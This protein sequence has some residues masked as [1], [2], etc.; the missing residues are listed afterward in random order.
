VNTVQPTATF[1]VPELTER[2]A[3][4]AGK[5]PAKLT[6]PRLNKVFLRSRLFSLLDDTR[7]APVAWIEAPPGAGKTTLVASW[8]DE[9]KYRCLWYQIDAR[10][11]DIATFFHYLGISARHAAPRFKRALPHLTP[12]Y[13]KGIEAFTRRYFEEL[14]ARLAPGSVV[15][16][17]NVQ[18]AGS[19]GPLYSV[20]R[21]AFETVPGHVR[22]VC[23]SRGSPAIEL[24]RLRANGQ[25]GVIEAENLRLTLEETAGFVAL[26]CGTNLEAARIHE[27]TGGWAAGIVLTLEAGRPIEPI[28]R[29]APQALFDYFAAEIWLRID[30]A[31]RRSL[32]FCALLP[33]MPVD[34]IEAI[35]GSRHIAKTLSDFQRRNYFTFRLASTLPIYD[36]HPLFREFLLSRAA[37]E[38][39]PHVISRVRGHAA[40]V[41]EAGG[42]IEDA[43]RL[44]TEAG[45]WEEATRMLLAHAP[46]LA[47]QGRN[48]TLEAWLASLP[49]SLIEQ[50][51]W[52]I[53]WRGRCRMYIN[54][55]ECREFLVGAF[56]RFKAGKD[57]RGML[58]AW[59]SISET[60]LFGWGEPR[61]RWIGEFDEIMA[62]N[63]LFP[64]PEIEARAIVNMFAL[65]MLRDIARADVPLLERK[66]S[67]LFASTQS[68][69]LRYRTA[70]LL[71]VY[72]LWMGDFGKGVAIRQSLRPPVV[73]PH[74]D[75]VS[76]LL[77]FDI[78][79]QCAWMRGDFDAC[80]SAV[81]QGLELA[82]HTGV[83]IQGLF[84]Y[85]YGIA[86]AVSLGHIETASKLLQ[87]MSMLPL[88]SPMDK[89]F[90]H[91]L[92]ALV[93]WK[94]G[95]F[96]SAMEDG[97]MAAAIMDKLDYCIGPY[98]CHMTAA[99]ACYD[100]QQRERAFHHLARALRL[101]AG[102]NY[103]EYIA[104]LFSAR[105][106][107][108][109]G[110]DEDGLAMLRSALALGARNGYV[111]FPWWDAA[112]MARLCATALE[113]GIETGYVQMLIRTRSL[114]PPADSAAATVVWPWPVRIH[115]LGKFA[116]LRDGEPVHY[117]GKVQRRPLALL[118][119]LIAMGGTAVPEARLAEVMWPDA[120]GDVAH[121][122]LRPALHRLRKLIGAE[123]LHAQ[124]GRLSLD[125]RHC[126]VDVWAV[127]RLLDSFAGAA[128]TRLPDARAAYHAARPLFTLYAG[129][130]LDG[131]DFPEVIPLRERLRT[132][133][134]RQA[135]D[136]G[137]SL[138]TQ[139]AWPEAVSVY[140]WGITIDLYAEQFYRGLMHC[141]SAL[142]QP[143]DLLRVYERCRDHLKSRFNLAPSP[144]TQ[145]LARTIQLPR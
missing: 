96:N 127:E 58:M 48:R 53:Y 112:V 138:R 16:F 122:N 77:W 11:A 125:S 67:A 108:D 84:F 73:P 128:A 107:L 78:G 115:T 39:S 114:A 130:F 85:K 68:A 105:I 1:K 90:Y 118:K 126:W 80:I 101:A 135:Y 64:S 20:L 44:F 7:H 92:T 132:R 33:G 94:E 34:E 10:D 27:R 59:I 46:D 140:E 26:R 40:R 8:L 103:L 76:H 61:A 15:V 4:M 75:P 102:R 37:E 93:A 109:Q 143:S 32:A 17:D 104:T 81:N 30:A 134:L 142:R 119:T 21:I 141:H 45:E 117:A 6:R 121:A 25:L 18:D 123:A 41:L 106:A 137:E 12:E 83:H 31:A 3:I 56:D 28:E 70:H 35:A 2:R 55:Y 145:A 60:I 24:A 88:V 131:E 9:R 69:A 49:A 36:F 110:K 120:D 129:P 82:G 14:F 43:M 87:Q 95:R 124:D 113:H 144:E 91:Y 71:V 54:P 38:L 63:P 100:A 19:E 65:L 133:L 99:V 97:E 72:H 23:L 13:L 98:C 139:H 79:A 51:P 57:L 89:S 52:L 66:V 74:Q 42:R 29:N 5:L 111:N 22:I 136:L 116:I 50:S 86:G 62:A 47:T